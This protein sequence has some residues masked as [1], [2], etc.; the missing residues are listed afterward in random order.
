MADRKDFFHVIAAQ[1]RQLAEVAG[2]PELKQ[3]MLE[4]AAHY[5]AKADEHCDERPPQCRRLAELVTEQRIRQAL[6]EM[7]GRLETPWPARRLSE[8]A[9]VASVAPQ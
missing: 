4:M 5:Q 2:N 1:Y 8:S 3:R 6:M 9:P 7:A